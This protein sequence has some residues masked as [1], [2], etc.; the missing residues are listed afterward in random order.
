VSVSGSD[1]AIEAFRGPIEVQAER[2]GVRLVPA[3]ALQWPL[4]V[5]TT[6]G[7]IDLAVPDGSRFDLEASAQRGQ[8]ALS[9][10]G[11]A[12]TRSEPSRVTG[13]LG[14]GGPPVKLSAENGD[15]RVESRAEVA[16]R[17]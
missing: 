5:R 6:F 1:V 17:P 2:A 12:V 3:A 13:R 11:L 14:A 10:P 4:T 7:S 16:Q 9:V 15:V 8:L